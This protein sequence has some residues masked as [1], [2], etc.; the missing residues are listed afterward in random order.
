[1]SLRL[2][3]LGL[4]GVLLFT[5]V[6]SVWPWPPIRTTFDPTH[7]FPYFVIPHIVRPRTNPVR[8]GAES[9]WPHAM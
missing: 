3:F 7:S 2:L 4:G 6:P 1:V 9:A 8:R 5:A